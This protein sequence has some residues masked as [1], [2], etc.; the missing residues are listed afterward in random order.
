MQIETWLCPSAVAD[1]ERSRARVC[2]VIDVLRAT[3]VITTAIAAGARSVTTCLDIEQAWEIKRNADPDNSPLLCGERACR[4]IEGFDYGNSPSE[5]SPAGVSGRELVM[6]TTNGTRAIEAASD[7]DVMML[8]CFANLS[9]VADAIISEMSVGSE[10]SAAPNRQSDATEQAG[11]TEQM[12][13]SEPVQTSGRLRIVCAGTDGAVTGEDVLLAGALI[14]VCHR[15]L[16]DTARFYEGPIDLVNDSGAIA[17]AAWQHCITHDK[18]VD[19][20]S[21]ARRLA[22]TD[23]GRNMVAAGYEQDLVDCGSIDVFDSVPQRDRVS[24]ARFVLR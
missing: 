17:L 18:V 20:D 1:H 13:G 24:P 6:T 5:Y 9:A 11:P 15:K 19:S 10:S 16:S 21:L 4:P 8:A 12:A 3:T 22:M 23:G 14:A 7:C 2:V